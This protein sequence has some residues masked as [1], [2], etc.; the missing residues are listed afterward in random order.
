MK[1]WL[2]KT[3]WMNVLVAVLAVFGKANFIQEN[4]AVILGAFSIIGVVL[5]LITKDRITLGE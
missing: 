5:R 2:S 3:I 4:A 1:P